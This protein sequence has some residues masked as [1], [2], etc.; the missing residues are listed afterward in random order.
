MGLYL[1]LSN[2]RKRVK[3]QIAALEWELQREDLP[4]KDRKI[5]EESLESLKAHLKKL[6]EEEQCN[7]ED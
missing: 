5:F 1:K 7:M 6:G 3:K 2:D 4:E